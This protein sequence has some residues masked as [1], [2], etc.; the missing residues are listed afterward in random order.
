MKPIEKC[1]DP[2]LGPCLVQA[3]VAWPVRGTFSMLAWRSSTEDQERPDP[4]LS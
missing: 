3:W 1:G 2:Y 4:W